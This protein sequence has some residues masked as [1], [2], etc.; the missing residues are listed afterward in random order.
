MIPWRSA[1][2]TRY[3]LCASETEVLLAEVHGGHKGACSVRKISSAFRE[4]GDEIAVNHL[5]AGTNKKKAKVALVLPLSSF[6]MVSVTVPAVSREAVAKLLPY[7]LSKILDAPVSDYIYD[8]QVVQ[9][10]TERQELTVYLYPVA[11][12]KKIQQ[13]LQGY[14][15][16]IVWFEADVFAA[17]SY[18][19]RC[20]LAVEE[21]AFLC[22]LIW[23]GSISMA[24]YEQERITLVRSVD[25][26]APAEPYHD[27]ALSAG[28]SFGA[29]AD[30]SDVESEAIV[31][32]LESGPVMPEVDAFDQIETEDDSVFGDEQNI[33][34]E[35]CLLSGNE[36]ET[37]TAAIPPES[38]ALARE[39]GR[40]R[41]GQ[42]EWHGY[43]QSINLEIMR[44]NDYYVSVLKGKPVGRIFVG[45]AEA[46]Y[47]ALEQ[48]IQSAVGI[49]AESFP[50]RQVDGDC[51]QMSAALCVGALRR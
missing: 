26:R 36:R 5:L 15:K 27:E 34:A 2:E 49:R 12:F 19:E 47:G 39:G 31:S 42:Q 37:T 14:Q 25:L 29:Q 44:T 32:G 4:H 46:F 6:E 3:A 48:A 9:A 38:V 1:K 43:L 50:P 18:L 11:I 40:E 16:E 28:A 13:K 10:F 21:G 17:C 45:G 8:W 33:L 35:F 7:N 24:T 30:E 23:Q 20:G 51:D 22:V 41:R